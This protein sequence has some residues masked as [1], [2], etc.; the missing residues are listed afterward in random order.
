VKFRRSPLPVRRPKGVGLTAAIGVFDGV[1]RGHLAIL[2][3]T[4]RGAKLRQGQ[5]AVITFDRHPLRTLAPRLAPRCLQTLEQRLVSLAKLGFN[6]IFVMPFL[7]GLARLGPRQFVESILARRLNLAEL[8]VGYD[9]HFG[10]GGKGD[11]RLLARL[12]LTAGFR[13]AVVPPVLDRGEPVSSTRIRRLVALGKLPEAARLLGRPYSLT[14]R[15]VRG[16]GRG[17][18]LGFP[19]INI[20]PENESLP[21]L[22]VYA[23]RLGS[24][25]TPGV[26][27]L[28]FS[29]T[30]AGH[31]AAPILEVH[32]I[33]RFQ[34]ARL[35]KY[36]EIALLKFLRP[37]RRFS[38]FDALRRQIARDKARVARLLR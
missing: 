30:F 21:P 23:V 6:H 11:A 13:V 8:V 7:P 15:R 2:R 12:G 32:V 34:P 3:R 20:R 31:R 28:G 38:N 37:E 25:G 10:H 35:P 9:F 36:M 19:T 16:A 27:N 4:L 22:G 29:P 18:K 26:A 14:G 1:H 24:K 33:S 17:R 5:A